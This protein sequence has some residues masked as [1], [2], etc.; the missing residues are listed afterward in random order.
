MFKK[1]SSLDKIVSI[2]DVKNRIRE[3]FVDTQNPD[4]IEMSLRMG[5]TPLSD[6][7]IEREEQESDK[8]VEKVAYMLPLIVSF[9][10]LY[11]QSMTINIATE[12][13]VE[14]MTP[15]LKTALKE[16][17]EQVRGMLEDNLSHALVGSI[18]QIVDL[19]LLEIP[20]GRR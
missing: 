11:A 15:D 16:L 8:R 12:A 14:E 18:T 2:S 3:F 7:L 13:P 4:A 1:K 5:C 17:E 6:E 10:N 20:K 19:E 9:A